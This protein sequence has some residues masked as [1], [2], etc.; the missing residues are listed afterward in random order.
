[1]KSFKFGDKVSYKGES[2]QYCQTEISWHDGVVADVLVRVIHKD[3]RE[4]TYPISKVYAGW[5]E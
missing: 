4:K 5:K 2:E 3:G 1:M